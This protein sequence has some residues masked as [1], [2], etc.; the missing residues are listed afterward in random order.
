MGTKMR[1]STRETAEKREIPGV[2][3]VTT[4]VRD[5]FGAGPSPQVYERFLP[6]HADDSYDNQH[7]HFF[8]LDL[9]VAEFKSDP[10]CTQFFDGRLT[11]RAIACV[12]AR[13]DMEKRGVVP[14]DF[15]ARTL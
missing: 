15:K 6:A 12:K 9:I 7:E 1:G 10:R 8:L 13:K 4:M 3:S 14:P 11:Q 5:D 2:K